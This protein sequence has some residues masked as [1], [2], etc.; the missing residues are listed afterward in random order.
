MGGGRH[1]CVFLFLGRSSGTH[2]TGGWTDGR[3]VIDTS[4]EEKITCVFR[5]S[6]PDF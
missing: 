6:N 1:A 5:G 4:G 3:A 2:Y